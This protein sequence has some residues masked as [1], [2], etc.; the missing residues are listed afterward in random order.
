MEEQTP[1]L[2]AADTEHLRLLA[3]FYKIAAWIFGFGVCCGLP[4]TT[5]GLLAVSGG[6][7]VN[8]KS[9]PM[10]EFMGLFFMLAGISVMLVMALVSF[11]CFKSVGWIEERKNYNYVFALACVLCLGG[12]IGIPLGVFTLVVLSRPQVKAAFQ[13]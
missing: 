8:E 11:F 13:R 1:E 10:P 9:E 4:H 12:M 2:T 6:L 3:L 7:P 5:I